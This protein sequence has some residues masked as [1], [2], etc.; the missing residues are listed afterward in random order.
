VIG[1]ACQDFFLKCCFRRICSE[2]SQGLPFDETFLN[3][4][5]VTQGVQVIKPS[6]GEVW[7]FSGAIHWAPEV[8]QQLKFFTF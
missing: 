4:W 3:S 5:W 7:I 6:M 8:G 2:Q 1:T